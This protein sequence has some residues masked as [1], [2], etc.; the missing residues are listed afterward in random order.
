MTKNYAL[1]TGSTAGIGLDIA[2]EL[3]SRGHNI[4]LTARREDRLKDITEQLI[5]DYGVHADFIAADLS[6][7]GAPGTIFNFCNSHQYS[8][9]ILVNNAGYSINKK[10]HETDEEEE[11]KFLRVLGTGV[12]ALTKRFIPGMLSQQSGKIMLVS[13]LAAFAPPATGWGALY[14]PVKTFVNRFGDALNLNYRSHGITSTNVCPGFTVT[15]FHTAS[16]MQD[17]MDQVPG[18]MKK[19]SKTVAKGAVDAM[20]KG[21]SVWVP[22]LLN[23]AIAF[24][25]NNLPTSLVIK[26]S[27]SL[28]GGRYE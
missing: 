14:G 22:G 4:L 9:N 16:G 3:A 20:M 8:V 15:E 18:F 11:E 2:K 10:F 17:A 6:E 5:L 13:S 28:A 19:D 27:S 12:V 26:M 21:K 25:C 7:L 24:L 1:I 23:K